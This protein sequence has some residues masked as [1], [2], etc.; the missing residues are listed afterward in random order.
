MLTAISCVIVTIAELDLVGS[1]A[2]LAV[3]VTNDGFGGI[4]GA[5]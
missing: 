2:D 4:A 3:T 5:V 1:A